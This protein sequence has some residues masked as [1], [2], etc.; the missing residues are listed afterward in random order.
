M[1]LKEYIAG[2]NNLAK[3]KSL[4]ELDV[5][6]SKDDEGNGF[7]KVHY[8]PSFGTYDAGSSGFET[9][10]PEEPKKPNAVLIN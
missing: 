5:V 2:L 3:D 10:N 1:T 9:F 4:L 7:G 6:H 8:S